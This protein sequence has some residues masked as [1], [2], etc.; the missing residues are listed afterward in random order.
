[1]HKADTV[2]VGSVYEASEDYTT[3]FPSHVGQNQRGGRPGFVRV[4]PSDGK[5][6]VLPDYSGA[7]LVSISLTAHLLTLSYRAGNRLLTSL[8]NIEATPLASLTFVDF[9]SGDILY[10]TGDARTLVGKEAQSIMPRQNIVT[11]VSVTGYTLV[12]DALPVRQ[13]PD[14]SAEQSPYSPPIR[15][16][17]EEGT[18]ASSFLDDEVQVTLSSIILHSKDLATFAW[19]MSRPMH[20]VPGQTAVLDFTDL[21]GKQAYAHMA[22]FR[23]TSINDD[24]IRTWTVSSAHLSPEGTTTFQ[25]TMREKPGGT[26]T[27][28]LFAIARKLQEMRPELM[29]DTS[30]LALQVRLVGIA[31]EFRLPASLPLSLSIPDNR[32]DSSTVADDIVSASGSPTV[33]RKNV[34]MLW[35]A[36]GI[37][38]TPFLSMLS[39]IVRSLSPSIE[40]V[41]EWDITL[42][43]SA[44]EPEVMIKLITAALDDVPADT[45]AE[46]TPVKSA[47]PHSKLRL[48]VDVFSSRLG[49][50]GVMSTLG[51][52]PGSLDVSFIRHSGRIS[53]DY[54]D[55]LEGLDEKVA[56]LC[57]PEEFERDILSV[58]RAAG[59]NKPVVRES[60]EY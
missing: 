13:K 15:L 35:I 32:A 36:G 55:T 37:G 17:A 26:V 51:P 56:Y 9:V 21:L 1:M 7:F 20:I 18:S 46:R 47:S 8:G 29:D 31:G 23:P 50:P 24:R 48:K 44:R 28:A 34:P 38:V 10:L 12:R 45:D 19:N 40:T 39:A 42:A 16:L 43:L 5:T 59:Y 22:P 54:V 2:F 11:L 3:K 41:N 25:L 58:L 14:T 60:F 49:D 6:V 33:N 4:R 27:G 57:G 30:P 52:G 53:Q